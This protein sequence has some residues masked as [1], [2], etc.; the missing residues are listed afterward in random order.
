MKFKILSTLLIIIFLSY[1]PSYSQFK[2]QVKHPK[3]T[4]QLRYGYNPGYY[5][6]IL[7][8]EKFRIQQSYSVSYLLSGGK[9]MTLGMY[10]TRLTYIHS[11]NLLLAVDLGYIYTPFGLPGKA[12][13]LESGMFIKGGELLYRPFKNFEINLKYGPSMRMYPFSPGNYR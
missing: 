1:S 7:N 3:I 9:G 5:L 13:P 8:P 4:N 6:G 10:S 12:S 11:S 2:S